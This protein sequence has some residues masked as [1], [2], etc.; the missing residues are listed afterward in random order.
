M[1]ERNLHCGMSVLAMALV[2]VGGAW[3]SEGDVTLAGQFWR[4]GVEYVL[5]DDR[6]Q[7]HVAWTK[8]LDYEPSNKN[9]LAGLELLGPRFKLDKKKKATKI[10]AAIPTENPVVSSKE[11]RSRRKWN[12]GIIFFQRMEYEKA[13][14]SWS[15]CRDLDPK[16]KD[17]KTGLERIDKLKS[18]SR[19]EHIQK[20]TRNI[21]VNKGSRQV[22]QKHWNQGILYFNSGEYE[23]ARKE[24][25]L[26]AARDPSNSDC[27]AGI[28]RIRDQKKK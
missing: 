6:Y 16:N 22:A 2:L 17:C 3:A 11:A 12:E 26:C 20:A 10:D 23:K 28:K 13:R 15:A 25:L 8:C 21:H 18:S 1:R 9:C 4:T 24:W 14:A 5:A 27:K 7:A 19:K